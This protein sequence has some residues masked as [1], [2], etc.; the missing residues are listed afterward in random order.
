[1]SEVNTLDDIVL[2]EQESPNFSDVVNYNP[3]GDNVEEKDYQR[4]NIA[5]AQRLARN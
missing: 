1:M 5:G 4:A 3:L 2:E